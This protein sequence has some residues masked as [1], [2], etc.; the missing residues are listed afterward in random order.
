MGIFLSLEVSS[1][2]RGFDVI[3]FREWERGY[4]YKMIVSLADDSSL[5]A[6]EF[7][8]AD[9]RHYSFHWQRPDGGMIRR[10]DDA[11]HYPHLETHPHHVHEGDSVR[12]SLPMSL[13]EVL[14]EIEKQVGLT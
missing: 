14:A 9:E 7:F 8:N 5:H 1:V 10:W 3:E 11:P 4:Y 12:A 2:V 6:R 13:K